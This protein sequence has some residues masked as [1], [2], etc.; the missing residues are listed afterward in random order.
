MYAVAVKAMTAGEGN[1]ISGEAWQQP[2][3]NFEIVHEESRH[4]R[5]SAYL[6]KVDRG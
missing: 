4:R 1:N 3:C 5:A 6:S 2:L